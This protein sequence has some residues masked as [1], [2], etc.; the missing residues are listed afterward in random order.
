MKELYYE[1]DYLHHCRSGQSI[2]V[3]TDN[4]WPS[5][6]LTSL[7]NKKNKTISRHLTQLH[8]FVLYVCMAVDCNL[9]INWATLFYACCPT[10]IWLQLQHWLLFVAC[11][12][13]FISF[14]TLWGFGLS[15]DPESLWCVNVRTGAY[16]FLL[17]KLP[18]GPLQ[19]C[20]LTL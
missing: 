13:P 18:E 11:Y 15:P 4:P 6:S 8:V 5:L 20:W 16:V 12:L 2:M 7:K 17:I 14:L 9:L 1:G 19:H 10:A 3:N